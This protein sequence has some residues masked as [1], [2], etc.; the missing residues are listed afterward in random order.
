MPEVPKDLYIFVGEGILVFFYIDN[1]LIASHRSFLNIQIIKD[2][3]QRKL[4]LCQ[5]SYITSV[6]MRYNLTKRAP[7]FTPLLV[8]ELKPYEGIAIPREIYF[9]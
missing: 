3:K 7:V 4:W 2:R 6:A 1:I 8:K 5:D 9:Y